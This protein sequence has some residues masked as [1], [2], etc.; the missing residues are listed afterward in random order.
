MVYVDNSK[1]GLVDFTKSTEK[2][3][4]KYGVDGWM[5]GDIPIAFRKRPTVSLN[6]YKGKV[7][8]IRIAKPEFQ[9]YMKFEYDKLIDGSFKALVYYF[10]LTDSLIIVPTNSIVKY[11]KCKPKEFLHINENKKGYTNLICIHPLELENI[12]IS[13]NA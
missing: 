6:D 2:E 3:D 1:V 5:D 4:R 12:I 9:N 7:I 13:L 10:K 8:T 11:L